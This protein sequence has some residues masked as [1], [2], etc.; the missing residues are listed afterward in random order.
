MLSKRPS[1]S[2]RHLPL[3]DNNLLNEE[4]F[5]TIIGILKNKIKK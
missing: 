4:I 3:K 2:N 5:I 1:I